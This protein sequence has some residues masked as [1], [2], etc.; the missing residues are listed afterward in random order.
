MGL[1]IYLYR[2]ENRTE[3]EAVESQYQKQSEANWEAVGKYETLSDDIK[4]SLRAKD[5]ALSTSLGLNDGSDPR[6]EKIKLPHPKYSDHYFKIGYFRSSYNDSGI[7]NVLRNLD[8]PG[9]Y[10]IMGRDRDE[11]YVFAPDWEMSL[12]RVNEAIELLKTKPNFR[13]F[14]VGSNELSDHKLPSSEQEA[15]NKFIKDHLSREQSM[16]G[17]SNIDGVFFPTKGIKVFALIPGMKQSLFGS[18]KS[19]N[20][21]RPTTFVV[22]EGE[23]EW[24][25]QALEIVRDTIQ[26]VI[27]KTDKDKYFLHWS[28]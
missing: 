2:Y 3:T 10:E 26:Y 23:N 14:D 7:N 19:L 24:Y 18:L 22:T 6:K 4:E 16:D 21:P 25:V 27:D 1:D 17:Y 13:C 20:I 15:L 9:L 8:V 5:K 11:D 12:I 28:G